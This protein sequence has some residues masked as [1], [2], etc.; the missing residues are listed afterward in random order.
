[1]VE[2]G[3][4]HPDLFL[5]AADRMGIAPSHSIVIEDSV[6]GVRAGV[7]AGMTVVGLCAASHVRAGHAERL[8]AAGA[9]YLADAWDR[10]AGI[11]TRL[12]E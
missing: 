5:M 11:V 10:A 6:G 2:R 9:H 1:M 3:K 4:P 8:L 7:A 12:V